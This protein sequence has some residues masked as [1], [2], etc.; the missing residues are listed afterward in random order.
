MA[1]GNACLTNFI[2]RNVIYHFS[3]K[4]YSTCLSFSPNGRYF[5]IGLGKQ[6]QVWRTPTFDEAREREFAPFIKHR[7]YNGHYKD[8][9]SVSWSAD[10]RFFLTTG[11]DLSTRLWA[12]TSEEGFVPTTLAGHQDA[13]VGAFFTTDQE[14]VNFL[15]LDHFS[16]CRF[17]L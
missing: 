6:L 1:D 5:A 14:T 2:R 8:I 4:E 11:K 3:F 13:L 15:L 17:T 16:H 9:T 7:N 12:L 10:S